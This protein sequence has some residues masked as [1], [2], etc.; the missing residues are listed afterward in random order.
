ML[1]AIA[2]ALTPSDENAGGLHLSIGQVPAHDSMESALAL[3]PEFRLS[4]LSEEWPQWQEAPHGKWRLSDTH[5]I[6][7]DMAIHDREVHS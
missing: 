1:G 6:E 7:W 5:W 3:L 4:S 2:M